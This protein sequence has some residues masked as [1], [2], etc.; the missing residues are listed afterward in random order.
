MT[1]RRLKTFL[2]LTV[3]LILLFLSVP[4]NVQAAIPPD[5]IGTTYQEAVNNLVSLGILSGN[6][7]GTYK[8]EDKISRAAMAKIISVMLGLEKQAAASKAATA[9]KDV[10][11]TF[12]AASYINLASAKGLIKGNNGMFK[13]NDNISYAEVLTILIRALG[14]ENTLDKK[15][16]WPDNYLV[17]AFELD[18]IGDVK[19]NNPKDFATRGNVAKLS[20]NA[21]KAVYLTTGTTLLEEYY[22]D[23]AGNYIK[24]KSVEEIAE[25]ARSTVLITTYQDYD[26]K[27]EVAS[28]SGVVIDKGVIVTNSHVLGNTARYKI[29]Y[30]YGNNVSKDYYTSTRFYRNVY[31]DI[32]LTSSPDASV[33]PVKLGN[34]DNLKVGQKVVAIGSPLGLKNTVSQGIISGIREENGNKLIQFD[35]TVTFGSSGGALFDMYGNLIGITT[36]IIPG[37]NLNF[38][39]PVNEV[40]AAMN[41]EVKYSGFDYVLNRQITEAMQNLKF[42][43]QN[44]SFSNYSYAGIDLSTYVANYYIT[45]ENEGVKVFESSFADEAFKS[46]LFRQLET[47]HKLIEANGY[48]EYIINIYSPKYVYSY[49]VSEGVKTEIYNTIENPATGRKSYE[50]IQRSLNN[51]PKTLSAGGK[52]IKF[53]FSAV[54]GL[55]ENTNILTVALYM[56]EKT[57]NLAKDTLLDENNYQEIAQSMADLGKPIADQYPEKR[58]DI[59]IVF[60]DLFKQ[61]PS[62][63]EDDSNFVITKES[64]NKYWV[65]GTVNEVFDVIGDYHDYL[66]YMKDN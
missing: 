8:P 13:P 37:E 46:F 31:K 54:Y 26:R 41:E 9:F 29:S 5:V 17:K 50:Q 4:L 59:I 7:D 53:D 3:S 16:T 39:I 11:P 60:S 57:F 63:Y 51:G 28:G 2:S 30:D 19:W 48:S 55:E 15:L 14:Y 56:T 45:D 10:T 44:I 1:N 27:T 33:K 58:L 42:G 49:K 23:A 20:W 43:G 18:I 12:W 52:S 25:L 24:E 35:A 38:A 36:A 62:K 21:M 34:S 22:P 40:K 66:W 32:A 64:S 65:F 61:Y 6:P 47:V